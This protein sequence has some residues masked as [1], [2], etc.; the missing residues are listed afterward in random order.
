MQSDAPVLSA[1]AA[2]VVKAWPALGSDPVAVAAYDRALADLDVPVVRDVVASL[3]AGGGPPPAPGMLRTVVL[4]R[5]ASARLSGITS[6]AR[7]SMPRPQ[8]A[9]WTPPDAIPAPPSAPRG[10]V[11]PLAVA[12]LAALGAGVASRQTWITLSLADRRLMSWPGADVDGGDVLWASVLLTL[13]VL[14]IGAFYVAR[15]RSTA[16]LRS[17]FGLLAFVGLACVYGCV[18][19]F[20]EVS[21]GRAMAQQGLRDGFQ[22]RTGVALPPGAEDLLSVSAGAGLWAALVLS[23]IAA[24]AALYGLVT[25]RGGG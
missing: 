22:D 4:S 13:A 10:A 1:G 14:A 24:A 3:S 20:Q 15:R 18:R 9:A 8:A 19:G 7:P 6:G 17:V 21:D 2:A 11:L 25:V 23:A 12:G 5:G 16:H